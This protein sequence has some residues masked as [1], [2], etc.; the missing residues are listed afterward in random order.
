MYRFLFVY[1]T[2]LIEG[3]GTIIVPSTERSSKGKLN[4]PNIQIVF[5]VKDFTLVSL[6]CRNIGHGSICKKKQSA[7]YIYTINNLQ[8]LV[9][10]VQLIIGKIRGHKLYQ[11]NK[12]IDYLNVKSPGLILENLPLDWSPLQNNSWLAGFIE[13]DGSFQVRT[14]LK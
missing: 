10:L 14:S 6:I 5:Q 4:Y 11:L 1:T 2:G 3:D 12:L 7:V 9:T 8:G 13:A